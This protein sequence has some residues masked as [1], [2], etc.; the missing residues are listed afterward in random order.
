[1]TGTECGSLPVYTDGNYCLSSWK[2]NFWERL[3]VLF[4]GR[5]WLWVHFGTS[6]PPVCLEAKRTPFLKIRK[7]ERS[8]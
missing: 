3:S 5:V 6:Q 2:M 1:M 8:L 4:F 7:K